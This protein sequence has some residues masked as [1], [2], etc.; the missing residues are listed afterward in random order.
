MI[1]KSIIKYFPRLFQ[2]DGKAVNLANKI[3]ADLT[4]WKHDLLMLKYILRPDETPA[5]A[6]DELGVLLNAGIKQYDSEKEKRRRIHD[7][8]ETHKLNGTWIDD[9]KKRIEGITGQTASL[10]SLIDVDDDIELGHLADD[11]DYYWGCEGIN[12]VDDN[13]GYWEAGTLTEPFMQT[14]GIVYIDIGSGLS[15]EIVDRVVTEISSDAIPAYYKVFLG[16]VTGSA[17]TTYAIIN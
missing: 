1:P 6:L 16:Y 4:A 13:L 5:W 9:A 12:G 17:W 14:S 10:Y 8:I 15:A 3:D 2:A 7:A 11:P